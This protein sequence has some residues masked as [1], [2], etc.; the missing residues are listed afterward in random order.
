[1]I[2]I[3]LEFNSEVG[4]NLFINKVEV[5]YDLRVIIKRIVSLA[6]SLYFRKPKSV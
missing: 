6:Y 5:M 4:M 2:I 1:M 3:F